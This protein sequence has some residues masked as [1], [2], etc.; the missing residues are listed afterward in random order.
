M[1]KILNPVQVAFYISNGVKPKNITVGYE[2]KLVFWFEKEKTLSVWEL[3][4]NK[5]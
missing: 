4:K 1:I 2:N 3:W 5:K